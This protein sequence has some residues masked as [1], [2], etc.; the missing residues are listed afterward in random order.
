MQIVDEEDIAQAD[1]LFRAG[2]ETRVQSLAGMEWGDRLRVVGSDLGYI[3]LKIVVAVAIVV[4]GRWLIRRI[5]R[6]IDR[7]ME[8]WRVDYPLRSFMRSVIKTIL[9]FVLFY[10][11]VVWLGVNTSMFVALFAAAG[12]AIGMAMSGV[13]QNIA[14]G[15]MVLVLKPFRCGDWIEIEGQEGTVMDMRLFSTV[16]RT[17]DNRTVLLPNG[18]VFTSVVTNHTTARTRRL[19][20]PVSLDLGS[21]FEATKMMLEELLAAEEKIN[22]HPAPKVVISRITAEAIDVTVYAWVVTADYWDV[23]FRMNAAIFRLLTENGIDIGSNQVVTVIDGTPP[24]SPA[25]HRPAV[26]KPVAVGQR[27]SASA[28]PASVPSAKISMR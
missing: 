16:L 4:V 10:M 18:E 15:V 28:E 22:T 17:D 20:W 24:S 7:L 19:E 1:S 12:L 8:K 6:G 26:S 5:A 21:D 27:S 3:G 9:Y 23:Y 14:G 11:V 13:F 2:I 25:A